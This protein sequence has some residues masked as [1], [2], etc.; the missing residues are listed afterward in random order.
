MKSKDEI[1]KQLSEEYPDVFWGDGGGLNN[2]SPTKIYNKLQS[3]E[4]IDENFP[5][6]SVI[7]EK[8][9]NHT[10]RRKKLIKLINQLGNIKN[11]R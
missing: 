9:G 1:L 5:V 4:S 2:I 10:G 3:L 11:E 8:I 7:F 6:R